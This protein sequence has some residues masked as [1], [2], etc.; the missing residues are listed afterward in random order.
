MVYQTHNTRRVIGSS[1]Q[2][3]KL[4]EK[5]EKRKGK[6]TLYQWLTLKTE[7]AAKMTLTMIPTVHVDENDTN[8]SP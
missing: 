3:V 8:G 6:K 4:K 7:K 2:R 1:E 5:A